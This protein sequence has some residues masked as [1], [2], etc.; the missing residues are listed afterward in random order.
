MSKTKRL[1]AT[2]GLLVAACS[3]LPASATDGHD[4]FVANC[5]GCHGEN[6]EGIEGMAPPLRN[7]ELW[8]RLGDK[9]NDYIAGVVTGGMSGTLN[10]GGSSFDGMVMPPQDFIDTAELV[11]ITHY[12]LNEVNHVEGGPDAALIDKLKSAPRSHE[13]LQKLRNGG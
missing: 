1:F 8:A 5:S 7:P 10:T 2:A 6:A 4:K 3:A 9:R 11:V 12:I 13:D